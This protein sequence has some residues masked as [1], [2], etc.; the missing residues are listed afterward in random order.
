V[1]QITES[2]GKIT[3]VLTNLEVNPTGAGQEIS[4]ILISFGSPLSSQTP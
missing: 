4:G 3:V 1:A 2:S